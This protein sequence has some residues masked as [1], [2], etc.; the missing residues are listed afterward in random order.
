MAHEAWAK[1]AKAQQCP[2][3]NEWILVGID[4]SGH[5]VA[6]SVCVVTPHNVTKHLGAN[7][8]STL[9][10]GYLLR[11]SSREKLPMASWRPE[12]PCGV[13][14]VAKGPESASQPD[15]C[16]FPPPMQPGLLCR[17]ATRSITGCEWCVPADK[18]DP[19]SE[20]ARVAEDACGHLLM[21]MLGAVPI[22][23]TVRSRV[24]WRDKRY[25]DAR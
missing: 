16:P 5:T 25:E 7:M 11:L 17:R 12:H 2:K 10:D 24:V 4:Q 8:Y 14:E 21:N 18:T 9:G 23:R 13:P 1:K 6:A 22:E 19:P 15:P 3:C 20:P